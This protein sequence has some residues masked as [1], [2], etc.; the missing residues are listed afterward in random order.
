MADTNRQR[1]IRAILDT[2]KNFKAK[3]IQ[4]LQNEPNGDVFIA[5]LLAEGI[6]TSSETGGRSIYDIS[7]FALWS[8]IDHDV[9]LQHLVAD[10][11][12]HQMYP[13]A[14]RKYSSSSPGY[15]T[16]TLWVDTNNI[17]ETNAE[18]DITLYRIH[19]VSPISQIAAHWYRMTTGASVPVYSPY[20]TDKIEVDL[21][22][23]DS[24]SCEIKVET[25]ETT[26]IPL[27]GDDGY[28]STANDL[29]TALRAIPGFENALVTRTDESQ[30]YTWIIQTRNFNALPS[31]EEESNTMEDGEGDSLA[32]PVFTPIAD[33]EE[34]S[35]LTQDGLGIIIKEKYFEDV[36]DMDDY[37]VGQPI[38]FSILFDSGFME[39]ISIG[40]IAKA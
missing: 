37:T 31:P 18:E 10:I 19:G 35:E 27:V 20:Q 11:Y 15:T 2:Y 29:Q 23:Y 24:G 3:G 7:K 25:T 5:K 13:F 36:A 16:G 22:T 21:T 9:P 6:K 38:R 12:R 32:G 30:V 14:V 17:G 33:H 40:T 26:V 8:A 1:N 34:Y 28:V 4:E 39:S